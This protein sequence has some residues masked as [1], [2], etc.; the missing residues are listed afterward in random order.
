MRPA[1]HAQ[2]IKDVGKNV[3]ISCW[4]YDEKNEAKVTGN[5]MSF[6][7]NEHNTRVKPN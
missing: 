4:I 3:C 2:Q 1:G 5:T 7:Q 6:S